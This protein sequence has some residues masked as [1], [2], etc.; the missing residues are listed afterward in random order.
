MLVRVVMVSRCSAIHCMFFSRL[1]PHCRGHPAHPRGVV[2]GSCSG[3]VTGKA[4]TGSSTSR[5]QRSNCA[6]NVCMFSIQERAPA[7]WRPFL[8]GNSQGLNGLLRGPVPA[9][10]PRLRGFP[11]SRW[12]HG[13]QCRCRRRSSSHSGP[14]SRRPESRRPPGRRGRPSFPE[15]RS[16][17]RPRRCRSRE[18]PAGRTGH[19]I[20]APVAVAVEGFLDLVALEILD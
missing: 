1:S 9:S 18:S 7:V 14:T 13:R 10:R 16:C 15:G 8:T 20:R 5:R 19:Q 12:L 4:V 3:A 11:R 2:P 6:R 17:S